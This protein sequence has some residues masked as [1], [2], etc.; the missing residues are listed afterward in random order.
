M[1][2]DY[3]EFL[4]E[5]ISHSMLMLFS[6]S[7]FHVLH[8]AAFSLLWVTRGHIP[9]YALYVQWRIQ[10]LWRGLIHRY[11]IFVQLPWFYDV[12]FLQHPREQ[13]GDKGRKGVREWDGEKPPSSTLTQFDNT[14][15][16]KYTLNLS[17]RK[18]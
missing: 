12:G 15:Y 1:V 16:R 14:K 3:Y 10:L 6:I 18:H 2:V 9:V 17:F 13:E 8:I 5:N 11:N 4:F 7:P